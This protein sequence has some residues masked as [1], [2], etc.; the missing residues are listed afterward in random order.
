MP[1]AKMPGGFA[2]L[3]GS[4]SEPDFD[5]FDELPTQPSRT[6]AGKPRGRPAANA[7]ANRVTKPAQRGGRAGGGAARQALQERN[8]NRSQGPKKQAKTDPEEE[9]AAEDEEQASAPPKRGRPKAAASSRGGPAS[10]SGR[11]RPPKAKPEPAPADDIP[12]MPS[13]E[14][15][16]IDGT[17]DGEGEPAQTEDEKEATPT[18]EL[19][20]ETMPDIDG[21]DLSVRRK[22]GDLTKRYESLE[23]RHKELRDVGVKEAERNYERL[24][25]QSEENTTGE[26][27]QH[28]KSS[29]HT[30]TGQPPIN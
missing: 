30:N 27:H 13:P 2:S 25:K 9:G 23:A 20:D 17:Q 3:L 28:C 16:E 1:R 19:A 11:G 10:K 5:S 6:M 24:K 21:D 18:P 8:N 29:D 7:G 4:D 22:L 12:E 15:M 26:C 14:S